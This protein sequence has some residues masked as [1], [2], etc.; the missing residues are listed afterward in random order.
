LKTDF[1]E[2]HDSYDL[3]MHLLTFSYF[4]GDYSVV[5]HVMNTN[6]TVHLSIKKGDIAALRKF[7][8]RNWINFETIPSE[9]RQEL[10]SI[11]AELSA[12]YGQQ[13]QN[14]LAPLPTEFLTDLGKRALDFGHFKD[15]HSAFN[16]IKSLDKHIN[17]SLVQAGE[18]LQSKE[19]SNPSTD[20][21]TSM[22]SAMNRKVSQAVD[23]VYR[24]VKLKN[25]FG[26]QFQYLGADFHLKDTESLR[27]FIKYVELNLLKE[28]IEFSISYLLDDRQIADRIIPALSSGK[29]RKFFLRQLAAQF[30]LGE[31]PFRQ[32]VANYQS[33]VEK[34]KT[35]K[36]E[37]D[38]FNVQK[39][40]LGRGTGENVA[41]QFLKEL[42]LEHPISAMLVLR[43]PTP[44]GNV[45]VAPIM[46]KSGVSLLDFLELGQA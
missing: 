46:L 3:V 18:L 30:S 8:A 4:Y 5:F 26:G 19:V 42:S 35:A 13:L 20:A 40:L 28:L 11:Y 37:V 43:Q 41:N 24:A 17:E 23:A 32:F 22:D 33:A 29:V 16:A 9:Q 31:E 44:G 38:Y 21:D 7:A 36:N 14:Q 45:I 27:K 25:P 1:K 15:A 12:K 10:D 2:I 34:L 39:T 6:S